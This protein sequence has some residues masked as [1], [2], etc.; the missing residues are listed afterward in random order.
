MFSSNIISYFFKKILTVSFTFHK[1]QDPEVSVCFLSCRVSAHQWQRHLRLRSR[2]RHWG[3]P[4][5]CVGKSKACSSEPLRFFTVRFQT[6]LG[7]EHGFTAEKSVW[8]YSMVTCVLNYW[9]SLKWLSDSPLTSHL[10]WSVLPQE[11]DQL[12]CHH[13]FSMLWA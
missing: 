2:R 12:G 6:S 10:L 13:Y 8:H 3:R 7:T 9:E 4:S 11:R 5:R 1:P